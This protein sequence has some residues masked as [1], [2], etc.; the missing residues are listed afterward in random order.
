M[1]HSKKTFE[2]E[3]F[4]DMSDRARRTP[5]A[6]ETR[7]TPRQSQ[8]LDRVI[9]GHENKQIAKELGVSEQ[10]VKEHVSLLL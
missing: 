10:A 5:T 2:G 1:V 3:L 6:N 7:L 9:R 8:V 4:D